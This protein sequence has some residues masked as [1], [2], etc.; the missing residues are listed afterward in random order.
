MLGNTSS[1]TCGTVGYPGVL[2][3]DKAGRPLPT[4]PDHT[5]RD[6][7]GPAPVAKLTVAPGTSV[8]FRLG[9]THGV[10]STTGCTTAYGLQVIPPND[11]ATL[12]TS[13]TDGAYECQKT[14][15]SPLQ[16]GE[17]AYR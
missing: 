4:L 17:S 5:A 13:I 16:P 2:F 12:H 11:T 10:T 7:V 14:T 9:V 6:F 8:S 15:V 1:H 3:L